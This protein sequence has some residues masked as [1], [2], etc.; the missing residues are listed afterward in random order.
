MCDFGE[1]WEQTAHE[2]WLDKE[3]LE[4]SHDKTMEMHLHFDLIMI[5]E[6]QGNAESGGNI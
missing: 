1:R 5:L 2:P 3:L 6:G 4:G